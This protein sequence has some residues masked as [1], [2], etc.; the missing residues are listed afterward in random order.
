MK[1]LRLNENNISEL[2]SETAKTLKKGG[3]A[4]APS[5]TVYGALVDATN[6]NAVEKLIKFKSRPKGKPISVFMNNVD[7]AKKY[8]KLNKKQEEILKNILPG[9]YT[10]VL[11]SNHR[12]SLLLESE[13]ET[14]GIRIVDYNFI[15][16]LTSK[17]KLPITATSANISS[18]SPHY[19]IKSFIKS[20][21]KSKLDLIDLIIDAGK[22]KLKQPSTVLDY[23]E[24]K[25]K[26]I[27][28]GDFNLQ[29]IFTGMSKSSDQTEE[30]AF[31]ILGKLISLGSPLIFIIQGELGAG[32]TVFVKGIGK[33]LGIN[34][35][36]SPSYTILEE[37]DIKKDNLNKFIHI[38]L[39]NVFQEEEFEY[40]KINDYLR[41]GNIICI[42]WGDKSSSL[43]NRMN[44]GNLVFVNIQ[45][46]SK[47]KRDINISVLNKES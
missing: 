14:L 16:K 47:D 31:S 6:E 17:Y 11:P 10:I 35:I 32:K 20:I 38:D 1:I 28:K 33:R 27:R 34:G 4:I 26:T 23:S 2:V 41:K 9:T 46:L 5:D 18:T 13:K 8:V 42:E 44:N 7:I 15:N 37:Y 21:P 19:S 39:Y 22:L 43:I 30:I 29:T 3:L 40:L 12:T 24:D 45:Y 25:V 36:T